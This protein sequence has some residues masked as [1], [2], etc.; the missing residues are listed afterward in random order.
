MVGPSHRDRHTLLGS[1]KD[2]ADVSVVDLISKTV[3]TFIAGVQKGDPVKLSIADS[4]A[5]ATNPNL[6]EVDREDIL[7]KALLDSNSDP[8]VIFSWRF[9]PSCNKAKTLLQEI[10]ADF[11]A[12]E[13]DAMQEGNIIRAVLGRKVGR[14]SVPMI[15]IGGKYIGGCDDGPTKDAPGL[16]RL[17]FQGKLRPMLQSVGIA[18]LH[19]SGSHIAPDIHNSVAN[20][21]ITQDE[22]KPPHVFVSSQKLDNLKTIHARQIMLVKFNANVTI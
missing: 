17:A 19:T 2:S 14:T 20:T 3:R 8:V 12:F 10:G 9:S 7:N 22:L 1:S 5:V 13:L 6:Q 11:K 15:F 16:V 18:L 4:I 21:V